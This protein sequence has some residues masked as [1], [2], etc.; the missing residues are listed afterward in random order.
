ME[1]DWRRRLQAAARPTAR[2]GAQTLLIGEVGRPG[3]RVVAMSVKPIL[4]CL[5]MILF[6]RRDVA[7]ALEEHFRGNSNR[8][9][10]LIEA[11]IRRLSAGRRK[12]LEAY[13]VG[14]SEWLAELEKGAR[15]NPPCL[16][17]IPP[18]VR[19][20]VD[21][22]T[23]ESDDA[24]AEA[25]AAVPS[26][27]DYD[28]G[29]WKKKLAGFQ[30][31]HRRYLEDHVEA[32]ENWI[33][34]P[35]NFRDEEPICDAIRELQALDKA[36][37]ADTPTSPPASVATAE[38]AMPTAEPTSGIQATV[39]PT[40]TRGAPLGDDS[41]ET[42]TIQTAD[43]PSS[44]VQTA[45]IQSAETSP[46]G[47]MVTPTVDPS[48]ATAL[49]EPPPVLTDAPAVPPPPATVAEPLCALTDPLAARA[50]PQIAP[51]AELPSVQPQ[52]ANHEPILVPATPTA[53]LQQMAASAEPP[54]AP[55][56]QPPSIQA[57]PATVNSQPAPT[58]AIAEPA[59]VEKPSGLATSPKLKQHLA[60]NTSK[61]PLTTLSEIKE[62]NA[63]ESARPDGPLPPRWLVWNGKKHE[64]GSKR[65][66]M[67]WKLLN[68][69]WTRE[70]APFDDLFD[71]H[72]HGDGVVWTDPINDS[73]VTTAVNRLN[74]LLPCDYPK[75]L[76]TLNRYVY[77]EPH[78]ISS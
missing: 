72:A 27:P 58:I 30:E 17:G 28:R 38:G 49:A 3:L 41:V 75:R 73:T 22:F 67:L 39:V 8:F 2:R 55:N 35:P 74:A 60:S 62:E 42:T 52:L 78:E 47:L 36:S 11:E 10:K 57:S 46:F 16:P 23:D 5:G 9:A 25:I 51:N 71:L 70:R 14:H 32:A 76:K 4:T 12:P 15:S 34:L 7:A 13:L 31:Q 54:L 45:S 29:N 69:M 1:W 26:L 53:A 40:E 77:W 56:A 48:L 68:F 64:I 65:G 43:S 59:S 24:F 20:V 37:P 61:P 63:S 6:Q 19:L 44:P 21:K 66:K 18:G 50:E 33:R